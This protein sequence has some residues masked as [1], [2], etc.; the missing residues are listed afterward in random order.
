MERRRICCCGVFILPDDDTRSLTTPAKAVRPITGR[1]VLFAC[2]GFFG[3]V[4]TVNAVMMTL[5]IR[6]MPGLDVA[7]G[8]VASQA[9]NREIAAMRSQTE[10]DWTADIATGLTDKVAPI[11]IVLTDKAGKPVTGLSVKA[12]LAHP[13]LTR[14]DHSGALIER[15]PGVYAADFPDVQAGA[16]TLIV[17]ASQS[18]ER[19]FTS[20]N[21]VILT[22]TKP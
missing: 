22:E 1:F 16:W 21:R 19:V 6:T 20:R 10:R 13:A 11:S 7:N 2:I 9:M 5:A 12:R 3:V 8:Y 17:E 18:G 14:A 15:R 4:A